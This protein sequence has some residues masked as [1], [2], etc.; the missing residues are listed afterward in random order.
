LRGAGVRC[1]WEL[2]E[3]KEG[4]LPRI[5]ILKGQE[6]GEKLWRGFRG[7]KALVGN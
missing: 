2:R 7:V 5:G 3:G 4:V 6:G 1:V